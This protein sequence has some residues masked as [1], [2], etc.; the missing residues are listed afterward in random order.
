MEN[1]RHEKFCLELFGGSSRKD[2]VINAGYSAHGAQTYHTLLLRR[3]D[4]QARLK[5]LQDAAASE[6]VMDVIRRK[7]VLSEIAA[8]RV[9]DFL[10]SGE[11]PMVQ[12]TRD[13]PGTAAIQSLQVRAIKQGDMI[14]SITDIKLH[15]PVKAI[16]ELNKMDGSYAP[17]K[18]QIAGANGPVEIVVKYVTDR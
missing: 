18:H 10:T 13:T 16:A 9:T 12:V 2:A 4:I 7:E 8:A 6:K 5:E 17:E 3:P 11:S 15:D 1:N 14:K